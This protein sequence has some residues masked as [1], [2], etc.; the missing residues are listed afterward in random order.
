MEM[1]R[2]VREPA[3]QPNLVYN[4]IDLN[5]GGY[6][7]HYVARAQ[8]TAFEWIGRKPTQVLKPVARSVPDDQSKAVP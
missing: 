8:G 6:P 5:S 1:A 7:A 3:W 2:A 4:V